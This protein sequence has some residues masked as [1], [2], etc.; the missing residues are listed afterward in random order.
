MK[1]KVLAIVALLAG[2]SV[3]VGASLGAFGATVAASTT[4]LTS[5][6]AI[7]DVVDE[8]AATGTIAA[9]TTY[10]LTFGSRAQVLAAGDDSSSP[11]DQGSGTTWPV[12]EVKVKVGDR[13]AKGQVLATAATTDV[14]RLIADAD[15]SYQSARIQLEQA[16]DQLDDASTTDATRQAKIGLYGAQSAFEKAKR[17][18][19]DLR[20]ERTLAAITAP[21]AGTITAVNVLAAADAPAG[22]AIEMTAG[23]L[24]VSTSVVESDV[25]SI[26]VGQPAGVTVAALDGAVL[27]GIVVSIEPSGSDGGSSGVVAFAVTVSLTEAPPTLRPGMSA[28][29]TITTATASGVLSIPSRALLG[30]AGSYRVR[31]MAADGSISLREVTAGLITSSLVEIKSG[32]QAGELVVTGT[33]ASQ[34]STDGVQVRGGA[35]PAG[36]PG[37]GQIITKG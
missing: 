9:S 20:A 15:R 5:E 18:L 11:S 27:D 3:A 29:V 8:V 24:V 36:G 34:N 30:T 7:A 35:F 16:Q 26:A 19:L 2:A 32:L 13:V 22:T 28:D 14:D 17:D 37:G 12:S 10:G 4:Y 33:S 25:A 21:A 6:A 23:Q 31:V 1:W